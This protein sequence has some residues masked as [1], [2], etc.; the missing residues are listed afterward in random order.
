MQFVD[1]L[2]GEINENRQS[3][4]CNGL[5]SDLQSV[6]CTPLSLSHFPQMPSQRLQLHANVDRCFGILGISLAVKVMSNYLCVLSML[7][8]KCVILVE[9]FRQSQ[10]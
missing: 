6:H 1:C 3:K 2:K 7:K 10:S 5:S 9:R 8:Y 4:N